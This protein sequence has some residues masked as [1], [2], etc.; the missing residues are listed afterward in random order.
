MHAVG[1]GG[2]S[3]PS[4][5]MAITVAPSACAP[6]TMPAVQAQVTGSSVA[7]SWSAVPGA[8]AYQLIAAMAPSGPPVQAQALPPSTTSVTYTGVPTGTYYVRVV[9]ANVCGST[10]T[11]ADTTV[12]VVP[13]GGGSGPRTPNPP[14]P[15]PPN[16]LPLPDRSAVVS[17]MARLYPNDLRNSCRDTGGNNVWLFRVVER[18]RRE[19]TRWGLNW[20]RA[21]VG[22]MS[23]DIITYNYGPEADEGTL[24]VH[25]V[26]VINGH[27]GSNPSW[28]WNNVTVLWSTG[29][30]W[31]LQPYLQAGFPQFPQ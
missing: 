2:I 23:Q 17:E 9:T 11:S 29:A 13:T 25:A 4:N 28:A 18:L 21:N 3:G 14:S 8:A 20:K 22:D 10:I 7:I 1:P 30:K 15:T 26:D 5:E 24:F 19:D 6:L 16:Y 31:T 12:S 27:C